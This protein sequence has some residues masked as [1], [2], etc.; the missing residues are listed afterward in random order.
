MAIYALSYILFPL[1]CR[2]YFGLPPLEAMASGVP[3]I[4]SNTTS[5]PE[6]CGDAAVYI[7]PTNPTSVADA[8]NDLLQDEALY[9][10]KKKAGLVRASQFTWHK[11]VHKFMQSI[12]KTGQTK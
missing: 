8:I 5:L 10:E 12:I 7:D 3:V 9:A 11:T 1:F 4:V 2:R 6:V